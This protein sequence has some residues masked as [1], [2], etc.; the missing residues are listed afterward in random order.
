MIF[1]PYS[2]ES[3]V[4]NTIRKFRNEDYALLRMTFTMID[5]NNLDANSILRDLLYNWGLVDYEQLYHGGK[6]GISY[7]ALFIQ[8]GK[9]DVVRLKFYRVNNVRGDRRF[10]IE[11]IRKRMEKGEINEGDLLYI[12]IFRQ[13]N[14]VPLIYF[15]NLTHIEQNCCAMAC[16][17][18]A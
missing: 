9:T 17:G 5:K 13:S 16:Q 6:F 3:E 10:S 15:I 12:S 1:S 14:G 4:I 11:K 8:N 7:N 18:Y 2:D